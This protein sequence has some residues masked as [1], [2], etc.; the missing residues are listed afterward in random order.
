MDINEIMRLDEE[1]Y[2]NTF[3]KRTPIA[4]THGKGS[5]LYDTQGKAYTDFL[6]GIA[7]NC[8]GYSDEGLAEAIGEQAKKLI[9]CSNIF[10]GEQQARAGQKAQRAFRR[11]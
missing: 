8:L 1:A 4:F 7:V 3:G 11:L 9:H 5:T 2:M 10:Y 6:A